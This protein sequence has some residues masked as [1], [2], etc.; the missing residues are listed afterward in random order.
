VRIERQL[1]LELELNL[2]VNPVVRANSSPTQLKC[3]FCFPVKKP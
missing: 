3:F 1:S 2:T